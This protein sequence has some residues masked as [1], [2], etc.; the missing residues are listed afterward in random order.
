MTETPSQVANSAPVT[1]RPDTACPHPGTRSERRNAPIGPTRCVVSAATM[2][3]PVVTTGGGGGVLSGCCP[4][5]RRPGEPATSA[6]TR[7]ARHLRRRPPTPPPPRPL[8]PP[9]PD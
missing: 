9:T 4:A 7:A 6:A 2:T 3:A 8:A 1:R 5:R